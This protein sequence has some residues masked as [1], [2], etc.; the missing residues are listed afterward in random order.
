MPRKW[1]DIVRDPN[2][3]SLSPEDRERART[4]YFEH[5]VA[6]NTDP[7]QLE[8]IRQQW[9]WRTAPQEPVRPSAPVA[10]IEQPQAG[11]AWRGGTLRMR[12]MVGRG[13]AGIEPTLQQLS[14]RTAAPATLGA[15]YRLGAGAA[16]LVT[17]YAEQYA[18]WARRGQ[19]QAIQPP[20][21]IQQRDFWENLADPETRSATLAWSVIGNIQPTLAIGGASLA[22]GLAGGP[23]A[24]IGTA[25]AGSYAFESGA[26]RGELERMREEGI[27][28]TDDEI[29]A[30]SAVVG[31]INATLEITGLGVIAS[32]FPAVKKLLGDGIRREIISNKPLLRRLAEG[33]RSGVTAGAAEGLTE[34]MQEVVGNAAKRV[35]DEN[36]GLFEGVTESMFVGAVIGSAFGTTGGLTQRV[37]RPDQQT[38]AQDLTQAEVPPAAPQVEPTLMEQAEA[39]VTQPTDQ[40][41]DD[42]IAGVEPPMTPEMVGPIEQPGAPEL[43]PEQIEAQYAAQQPMDKA[44]S[45]AAPGEITPAPGQITPVPEEQPA[46][47]D[48]KTVRDMA[49]EVDLAVAELKGTGQ[50]IEA[51]R[52]ETAW[53]PVADAYTKGQVLDDPAVLE[54]FDATDGLLN[55]LPVQPEVTPEERQQKRRLEIVR[56]LEA[57]RPF[58]KEAQ[59]E[60]RAL[61][62]E[63][64]EIDKGRIEKLQEAEQAR[65]TDWPRV[66][67]GMRKRLEGMNKAELKDLARS[68]GVVMSGPED[69]VRNRLYALRDALEMM[70]DYDSPQAY[71]EALDAGGMTGPMAKQLADYVRVLLPK[72]RA[73]SVSDMSTSL[74]YGYLMD[75]VRGED[76]AILKG[77]RADL[78]KPVELR[79]GVEPEEIIEVPGTKDVARSKRAKE[80]QKVQPDDDLITFIAKRGGWDREDA[81][82]HGLTDY[83][84]EKRAG[85]AW[86]FRKP[87]PGTYYDPPY[88]L[89][90]LRELARDAGYIPS[91]MD[92]NAF[93]DLLDRGL[94][95]EDIYRMDLAAERKLA[96]EEAAALEAEEARFTPEDVANDPE[97]FEQAAD[98][99]AAEDTDIVFEPT[100][101]KASAAAVSAMDEALAK[102]MTV[103]PEATQR[104]LDTAEEQFLGTDQITAQL[105]ALTAGEALP[106]P[107]GEAPVRAAEAPPE[108]AAPTP[109]EEPE[110]AEPG[111]PVTPEA[112]P[113]LELTPTPPPPAPPAVQPD[114]LGGPP[115]TLAQ[116]AAEQQR[117]Q[118]AAARAAAEP[119]PMEAPGTLFEPE[120][121]EAQ[122]DLEEVA[123]KPLT[124]IMMPSEE[125]Q[126]PDGSI[127]TVEET[128]AARLERIDNKLDALNKML[129]CLE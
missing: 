7:E 74:N 55:Q 116:M 8:D 20:P 39:G 66:P 40:V 127:A 67:K 103:D 114:M 126:L 76:V 95:G 41:I 26:M 86:V 46:A 21:Q 29:T 57:D 12:E 1:F 87:Q 4:L 27:E 31:T 19:E 10:D 60:Q 77:K 115:M 88:E 65:L 83:F 11:A 56:E 48:E 122:V 23:V 51:K 125:V 2:Y 58:T 16:G 5:Y 38:E 70:A 45:A 111:R 105:N 90:A 92:D 28:I 68:A 32:R 25:A 35:Y 3:Q 80:R 96:E 71:K 121:P 123:A 91:T 124:D 99:P 36:Q 54:A 49:R 44:V 118:E 69:Q 128:A 24:A 98:L 14:E 72:N 59:A 120:V 43:T 94:R 81:A 109:A 6:P 89:G 52:I 50:D 9:E 113:P 129:G 22:A 117:Q 78:K 119:P 93:L 53:K 62:D 82:G 100:D 102:A 79:A 42:A 73:K 13:I 64:R 33:V 17:P 85:T 30:A 37:R 15:L 75:Y 106:R 18:E 107:V 97:A 112:P 108:A 61:Y 84:K 104:I 110:L 63:L 34:G 101:Q 47:I